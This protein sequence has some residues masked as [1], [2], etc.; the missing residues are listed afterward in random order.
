MWSGQSVAWAEHSR[1][2]SLLFDTSCVTEGFT[3]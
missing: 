2:G 3:F 1:L